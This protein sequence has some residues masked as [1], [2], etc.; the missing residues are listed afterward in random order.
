[1]FIGDGGDAAAAGGIAA[2]P[3]R[4]RFERK[5]YVIRKRVEH[6]ADALPA[7]PSAQRVL[8]PEPVVA[9]R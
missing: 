7:R 3:S 6:A 9:A 4:M 8:H 2:T 5:L 1:M